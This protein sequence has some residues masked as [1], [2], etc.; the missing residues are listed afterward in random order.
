M[1]GLRSNGRFAGAT[2]LLDEWLTGLEPFWA[3]GPRAMDDATAV[4]IVGAAAARVRKFA[5]RGGA[6]EPVIPDAEG[7]FRFELQGYD[8]V[9][10]ASSF[11]PTTLADVEQIAPRLE[12]GLAAIVPRLASEEQGVFAL[13]VAPDGDGSVD[14]QTWTNAL[15]ALRASGIAWAFPDERDP[16]GK[17][18]VDAR[19]PGLSLLLAW[20]AD[21]AFARA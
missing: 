13:V 10:R 21:E 2:R 20:S 18:G 16:F 15:T 11:A 9:A 8:Y 19:K 12:A 14:A 5:R 1:L 17:N 3:E 7:F 6:L 4:E